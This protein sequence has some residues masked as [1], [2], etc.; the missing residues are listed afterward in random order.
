MGKIEAEWTFN[1]DSEISSSVLVGNIEKDRKIILFGTKNGT[2]YVLDGNAEVKLKFSGKK[3]S[4]EVESLFYEEEASAVF[5]NPI[6]IDDKMLFCFNTGRLVCFNSKYEKIWDVDINSKIKSTPLYYKNTIFLTTLNGSLKAYKNGKQKWSVNVNSPIESSPVIFNNYIVFGSDDG[7]I[8]AYTLNGREK[9]K[10]Q[11]GGKI[12]SKGKISKINGKERLFIGSTDKKLYCISINGKEIWNY[13]TEGPIV[14]EAVIED[15]NTDGNKEV[16]FGALDNNLYVLDTNG[17]KEWS[18]QTD[19]WIVSK[20]ILTDINNDG[21]KEVIIGSYDQ[22]I[23]ILDSEGEFILDYVPGIST[24]TTQPGSYSELITSE[25]GEFVGKKLMEFDTK[26]MIVGIGLI[27]SKDSKIVV[28]TKK[29][30][31]QKLKIK[32]RGWESWLKT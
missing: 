29:G 9:W 22:K 15:I 13:E 20:P 14:S 27:P 28:A 8:H 25:P 10:F 24:A 2:I 4:G 16:I 26:G 31:I 7:L 12:V 30:E 23:Y 19:F 3:P 17:T 6:L 1:A 21:K 11:T 18:F 32:K 5:S